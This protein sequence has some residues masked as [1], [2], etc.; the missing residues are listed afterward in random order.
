MP[1]TRLIIV[2]M[3]TVVAGP[4][5][6]DDAYPVVES[7]L[8]QGFGHGRIM[9]VGAGRCSAF[10]AVPCPVGHAPCFRLFGSNCV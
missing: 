3:L 4:V 9:P 7:A 6:A 10:A 8:V 2:L 1:V 5:A